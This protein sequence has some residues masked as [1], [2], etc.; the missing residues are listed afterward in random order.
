[1]KAIDILPRLWRLPE[2]R[3]NHEVLLHSLKEKI[4]L[5]QIIGESAAFMKEIVK[6]PMVA[7]CDASVL[8]SGE[9]GTGKEL[10]ARAIHYLSRRT[11]KSFIPVN[12]GAIP[13][14]LVE[15]ELFGHVKGAFTGALQSYSGLIR[16][17]NRGTLFLDEIAKREF[18][19]PSLHF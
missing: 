16:E 2:R 11:S 9:T 10:C 12:C 19:G 15:N 1:M 4:G 13:T 5:K 7:K 18:G 14:E 3:R 6:I 17:A 8:I